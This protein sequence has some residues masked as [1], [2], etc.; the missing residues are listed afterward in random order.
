M[1]FFKESPAQMF[2][3]HIVEPM[4]SR[5]YC[6][7][8]QEHS[9]F[10]AIDWELLLKRKLEPLYVPPLK[11][12]EDVSLFDKRFTTAP[13]T[14]ESPTRNELIFLHFTLIHLVMHSRN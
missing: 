8:F 1:N 10:A 12:P 2:W 6:I 11:G 4:R 14:Q 7:V 5:H 13:L 9:W 3:N